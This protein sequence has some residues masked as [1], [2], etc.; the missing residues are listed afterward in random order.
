MLQQA[1]KSVMGFRRNDALRLHARRIND[2]LAETGT[3]PSDLPGCLHVVAGVSDGVA[4]CLPVV[5]GVSDGVVA[6]VKTAARPAAITAVLH[7][8]MRQRKKI[9][10]DQVTVNVIVNA[11]A[12]AE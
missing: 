4:G 10:L 9:Y 3:R 12:V 11:L 2:E 1:H 5:A 7:Q 8:N 6:A